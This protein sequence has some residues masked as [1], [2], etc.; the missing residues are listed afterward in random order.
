M[1]EKSTQVL[2]LHKVLE[3]LA[4]MTTFSAGAELARELWPSSDLEEARTWQRETSEARL[5]MVNQM[6]VGMGG[7]RDV[8]D[9]AI[10]A[11]RGILIEPQTLLDIRTTLKR[12]TTIK[13]SL[14]RQRGL[15]PLL[16]EVAN[17][18]EECNPLQEEIARV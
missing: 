15:Y 9:V 12:A 13:R 1:N 18:V 5:L 4:G 10:S 7:A 17:E 14:G 6:N 16:G 2:E 3:K 11:T 8:R